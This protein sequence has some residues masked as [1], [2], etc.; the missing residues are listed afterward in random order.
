MEE[1]EGVTKE[2]R[3]CW[4]FGRNNASR[5]DRKDRPEKEIRPGGRSRRRLDGTLPVRN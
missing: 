4:I 2:R 5:D 3:G 1:R